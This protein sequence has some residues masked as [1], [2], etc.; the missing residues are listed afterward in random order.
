MGRYPASEDPIKVTVSMPVAL[1]MRLR[2]H[3][4]LTGSSLSQLC[5]EG[6]LAALAAA[7]A[8]PADRPE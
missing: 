6:A 7:T 4:D 2:A 5:R 8:E 3:A 1:Y